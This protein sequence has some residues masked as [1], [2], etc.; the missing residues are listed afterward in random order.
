MNPYT[1]IAHC[2]WLLK[3]YHMFHLFFSALQLQQIILKHIPDILSF[4]SRISHYGSLKDND[5]LKEQNHNAI[6]TLKISNSIKYEASV[7]FMASFKIEY[8]HRVVLYLSISYPPAPLSSFP[9]FLL[10]YSL[11][12]VSFPLLLH[13]KM[14]SESC[15]WYFSHCGSNQGL[16]NYVLHCLFL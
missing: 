15:L 8:L 5:S 10:P 9:I 1:F 3:A 14:M 11:W 7:T 16:A 6:I 2:Q 4:H 12:E 13:Q